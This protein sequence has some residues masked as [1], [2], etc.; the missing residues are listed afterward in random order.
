MILKTEN[1]EDAFLL[2]L[3][4]ELD[5]DSQKN[6][7]LDTE[8]AERAQELYEIQKENIFSIYSDVCK[9]FQIQ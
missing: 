4:E 8:Q 1:K 5:Y 7:E 9:K 3:D 2:Y 6:K